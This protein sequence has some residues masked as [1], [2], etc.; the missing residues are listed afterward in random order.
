M[1]CQPRD[2]SA[3]VAFE[4]VVFQRGGSDGDDCQP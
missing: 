3:N 2:F 1:K 4:Q